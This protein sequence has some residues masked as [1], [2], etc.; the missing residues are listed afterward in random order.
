MQA[1]TSIQKRR[2]LLVDLIAAGQ[3]TSQQSLVDA[4]K[5]LGVSVT[6]AT[7]SRD[8]R[9]LGAQKGPGGYVLPGGSDSP[10]VKALRTWLTSA[11]AAQNQVV[12]R[13]PPGGASPLAVELDA[14]DHG[15][16]LGTIAGDDTILIITPSTKTASA[17][18]QEFTVHISQGASS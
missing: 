13:T 12:L 4:L 7:L 9:D 10:L 8:L 18:V 2:G 6:Q 17:L 16:I 14:C 15:S 5:A 3:G 1:A 11:V